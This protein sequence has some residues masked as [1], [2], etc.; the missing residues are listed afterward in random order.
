KGAFEQ[1]NGGT[2]FL[3]ESGNL[4]YEIQTYLLRAIQERKIRKEGGEKEVNV[5]VRLIVASNENLAEKVRKGKFRED[6]FHRLNEFEIIMPPLRERIEDLGLFV[7]KF[8]EDG[9]LEMN[10][11]IAG[12]EDSAFEMMKSY[13]WPGNIRELKNTIRRACL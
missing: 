2:L 3:D 9:N 8:I 4:D 7:Q 13:A 10:K 1:A 6:L 5:K 11:N 12:I